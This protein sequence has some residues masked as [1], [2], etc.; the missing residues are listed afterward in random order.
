[1]IA[2]DFFARV[3]LFVVPNF[4]SEDICAKL[5]SALAAADWKRAPVAEGGQDAYDEEYRKTKQHTIDNASTNEMR[6]RLLAIKPQLESHFRIPLSGCQA[7]KF[8]SYSVGEFF[9]VHAD[10]ADD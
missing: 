3:G 2:A 6:V 4:L 9:R 5:R 7:P 8:L 1:M 10:T